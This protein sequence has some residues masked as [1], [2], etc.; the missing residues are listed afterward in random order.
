M[1]RRELLKTIAILTGTAVIGGELFLSGCK[2]KDDFKDVNP[3]NTNTSTGLPK[4]LTAAQVALLN[5]IGETIIPTTVDSPGAKAAMVGELIN[6]IV[7][8]C[9]LPAHQKVFIDGLKAIEGQC[10]ATY[11]KSFAECTAQQ[12]KDLLVMLEKEAKP[13]N[14]KINK[15]DESKRKLLDESNN[16]SIYS[17]HIDFVPSARHYYTMMKQLTLLGYFTSEVGMTKARRHVAVPGKYDGAL[18][19]TKGDKAW[20]E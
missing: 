14:E 12:K 2:T 6:T 3:I 9:Y 4:V 5:E 10:M 16:Q 1:D 18:A 7:T 20:A 17:K 15:E 8:D 13:F 11:K 19:Y